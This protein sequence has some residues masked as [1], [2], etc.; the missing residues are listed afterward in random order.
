MPEYWLQNIYVPSSQKQ[1]QAFIKILLSFWCFSKEISSACSLLETDQKEIF[2]GPSFPSPILWLRLV[3][4][5]ITTQS[6]LTVTGRI[7]RSTFFSSGTNPPAHQTLLQRSSLELIKTRYVT[8]KPCNS[9]VFWLCSELSFM[10]IDMK[11]WIQE[12]W[13]STSP[14]PHYLPFQ[15]WKTLV[16]P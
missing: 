7:L 4:E 1:V 13:A 5:E 6:P 8:S 2:G 10:T 14:S 16:A 3:W 11:V 15:A 12:G 9:R